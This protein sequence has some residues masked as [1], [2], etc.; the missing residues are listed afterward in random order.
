VY[1]LP[2]GSGKRFLSS[3]AAGKIFSGL[4]LGLLAN[5]QSGPPVTVTTQ[6]NTTNAFSAGGQ[7]ADLIGDPDLPTSER[8]TERWFNTNA[9]AQPSSGRFGTSGRSILRGDGRINF[10]LSLLKNITFSESRRLQ[11][12]AEAINA[13]NHPNFG[14]PGSTLGGPGFGVV[15]SA[16]PGRRLQLGVRFVF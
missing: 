3:S 6:V 7:R 12:R 13:F 8:T 2:V 9:F 10:D 11:L 1:E 4:S 5:I 14:L 15:N 16:E